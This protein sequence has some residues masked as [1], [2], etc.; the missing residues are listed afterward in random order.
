[1]SVLTPKSRGFVAL[2]SPDPT[3]KPLILH[4]YLQ[5]PDDLAS[6]V[7]G[8]RTA[9]EICESGRLG[10]LST[11]MLIGPDSHSDE[12]IEAHCRQRLQTLYH[13][14]GTCRMGDDPTSVVDRDLKVRGVEG[15]R[16]VDASVMPDVIR[17]NTNAPVVM[18]A[19]KAADL[20]LGR[21]ALPPDPENE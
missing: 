7:A 12:D 10:E 2:G 13:P 15:L 19:E 21:P 5:H 3:A 4:N 18:I 17:G 6:A 11:G 20:I 14:V 8:V 1:M 9:L 16:V